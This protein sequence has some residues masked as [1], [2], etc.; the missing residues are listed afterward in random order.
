MAAVPMRVR[1]VDVGATPGVT[2][3]A[4]TVALDSK[5]KLMD[6]PGIVFA[7]ATTAEEQAEVV[8]RNC[9]RVEELDDVT[10]PV[11]AILRRCTTE[12][13][14]RQYDVASFSTAIEF[15]SMS[16]RAICQACN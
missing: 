7:R 4:Q 3:V 14:M 8:L 15:R 1:A 2:T 16:N 6:C 5:V 13:L 9:V 11:E 12:Q 10:V